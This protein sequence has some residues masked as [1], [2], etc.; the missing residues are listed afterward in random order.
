VD[1]L[2]LY[3]QINPEYRD[4][5][6]QLV[7]FPVNA[8]SN[9]YEMY[10]A[11]AKNHYYA[12]KKDIKANVW[13]DKANVCFVRDSLLTVHYNQQ[14][15][16]GK[17]AHIMDQTRIGYTYWQQPDYNVMPKVEYITTAS[18]S[19][20][21]I[22]KD[23][24]VSME[25]EHYSRMQNGKTL[26]WKVIPGLGRTLSGITTFPV[27]ATPA[28][29]DSVYLEYGLNLQSEGKCK[30]YVYLS[31]TLNFNANKGLRYAVSF[32]GGE[33]QIVNFNGHYRGELGQWQAEHIIIS[34]TEHNLSKGK[35]VL[36]F[37]VLDPAIVL[38]K[39]VLDTGGL[40]PSYL[41]APE[42][43]Y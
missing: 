3:N 4:A 1:A 28:P 14:I 23:G 29:N 27:T 36:R 16:G 11:V 17:W 10:Y 43:E 33:E 40:K 24:Y 18:N 5:F 31:P 20:V 13:A 26:T 41:G 8:C 32:D 7:L 9:L 39:I 6:D 30:L 2:R 25:A 12:A 42:S 35:H 38:Q 22:E 34:S 21:F 19:P 37:R 15:T